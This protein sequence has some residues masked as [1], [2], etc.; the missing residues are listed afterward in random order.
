MKYVDEV[1]CKMG[2][3]DAKL[4]S[5]ANSSLKTLALR[6]DLHLLDAQVRHFGTDRNL[7]I[8]HNIYTY[9]QDKIEMLFNTEV[10]EITKGA[11]EFAIETNNE[12][13]T[14]TDLILATGRSGSKWISGICKKLGIKTLSNR[15]DIGVRV[16]LSAEIFSHIT[17]DVYESKIV[18]NIFTHLF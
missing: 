15:V 12:T 6:N 4:Y 17:D 2:G 7:V 1:N 18:Y 3:G 10:L 13:F 11:D 14:S 16:E 5:T 9:L 8:L